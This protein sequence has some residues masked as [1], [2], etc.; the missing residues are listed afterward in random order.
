MKNQKIFIKKLVIL[1]ILALITFFVNADVSAAP[2]ITTA[3]CN[4]WKWS[5]TMWMDWVIA[6]E[7]KDMCIMV[8]NL[9]DTIWVANL[10]FVDWVINPN[11]PQFVACKSEEDAKV[12]FSKFAFFDSEKDKWKKDTKI[13]FE[14]KPWESIIKKWKVNFSW[15][16]NWM[17]Y[18]CL[19]TTVWTPT[20]EPWKLTVVLRRWNTIKA[21]VWWEIKLWFNVFNDAENL[22]ASAWEGDDLDVLF[23]NDKFNIVR[24]NWTIYI[25]TKLENTWNVTMNT[26]LTVNI[27]NILWYEFMSEV[28]DVLLPWMSRDISIPVDQLPFYK[29]KYNVKFDISRTP[30]FEFNSNAI[31]DE[32]RKEVKEASSWSF[33]LFPAALLVYIIVILCAIFFIKSF[34]KNKKERLE[35]S[36]KEYKVQKW[37]TLNSIADKFWCDW[38]QIVSLNW[39]QPPYI[40]EEWKKII[41]YDFNSLK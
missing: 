21:R 14:V 29:G 10:Y 26:K 19:I 40:I 18:W 28:S 1:P 33:F 5:Q 9:W 16:F 37:D 13:S 41:V 38:K 15:W 35:K 27:S 6:G 12:D 2:K 25:K 24:I 36:K 11:T 22:H 31:T 4:D 8:S 34:L 32:M 20:S 3:F 30:V 7:E 39:I 17:S 23:S